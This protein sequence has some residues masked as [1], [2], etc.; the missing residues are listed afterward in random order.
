VSAAL[1]V[2][3]TLGNTVERVGAYGGL[4]AMIGLGVL[5]LLYF[6]QAREVKRLR[7]WAGRAPE[8]AAE[9]E[10]RVLA[11]AQKRVIAE[12][13]TAAGQVAATPAGAAPPA[14]LPTAGLTGEAAT[15]AAAA[16]IV[17]ARAT[18][19]SPPGVGPPGQ[20]AR[21]SVPPAGTPGS[22]AVPP[23][24]GGAPGAVSPLGASAAPVAPGTP[25][26][27]VAPAAPGDAGAP[28]PSGAAGAGAPA[29]PGSPAGAT[30]PAPSSSTPAAKP[31]T[32]AAALAANRP[33]ATASSPPATSTPRV[34]AQPSMVSNGAGQ[35]TRESA[36]ARP[37][38]PS[39]PARPSTATAQSAGD[40]GDGPSA[41]RL[42]AIVG[43][44]LA[45]A[46]II[47]LIVIL[48]GGG[49]SA[50]TKASTI[51]TVP[52][53]SSQS[54][55]T[56]TDTS[57]PAQD[58]VDRGATTT[59]VLNGTTQ[60][61][62]A[63]T[64]Q[65]KLTKAGFKE[66]KVADNVDQTLAETAIYYTDGNARAANEVAKVIGVPISAVQPVDRNVDVATSGAEVVVTVGSDLSE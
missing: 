53:S 8:R 60:A 51:G 50:P 65:T 6:A 57:A 5:S 23:P 47:G 16:A 27:P 14:R 31:P 39:P 38:P 10:Q 17:A 15:R 62:L 48:A 19:P 55:S 33:T 46:L 28:A 29:K 54:E 3:S 1:I 18:Q 25:A 36:A 2:A 9:V 41:G 63:S 52:P 22:P 64:V 20:L 45:V 44:I 56:P 7:E 66:G 32:A 4:A 24:A 13:Q 42:L 49:D 61:G 58:R 34:V 37:L 21:P 35:E 59:T 12:P 11:D 40:D 30:P 43:G 26:A